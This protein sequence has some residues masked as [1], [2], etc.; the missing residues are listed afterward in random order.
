MLRRVVINGQSCIAGLAWSL[1]EKRSKTDI[2][3]EAD[4]SADPYDRIIMLKVQYGLARTR[5]KQEWRKASSLAAIL[6]RGND[7]SEISIL[8]LVD[9][10]T[11]ES[12][13]W[14]FGVQKGILSARADCCF[15]TQDE[16]EALARSL[17]D[18]LG[19]DTVRH[20][21]PEESTARITEAFTGL[22]RS[23]AQSVRLLPLHQLT[24]ATV[25]KAFVVIALLVAAVWGLH[26]YLEYRDRLARIERSRV[27]AEQKQA[28]IRD[29]QEHPERHFPR[30]W[31]SA[32][33]PSS[34]IIQCAPAMLRHPLAANGWRLSAL[35]CGGTALTATWEHTDFSEYTLLPF[36]AA[37]DEKQ[38]R[39][40]VSHTPIREKLPNATR[41]L[42][43][44]LSREEAAR[45]LYAFTQHFSLKTRLSW[46]KRTVKKVEKQD[47][48]CPWI[49]S[50]W[51]LSELPAYLIADYQSLAQALNIPGLLIKE[52]SYT[53]N[54]WKLK[55]EIYAK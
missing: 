20:L 26:S 46:G 27:S 19:I 30:Q 15:T 13:W 53:N 44:L 31:M 51:E 8:S 40:A 36:N 50:T 25:I 45:R 4:G 29:A 16:A 12:F 47:V 11:S 55:G 35:S 18:T 33:S 49:T 34:V 5:G 28:R 38:P 14:V 6:N 24:R 21:S 52:L 48:A 54:S 32:P 43:G 17:Q 22:S 37:L 42:D 2:I 39:L 9:A 3:A 23:E 10:D 7:T 1:I 41:D